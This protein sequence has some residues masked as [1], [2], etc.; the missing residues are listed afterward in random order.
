MNGLFR[1]ANIL[2]KVR[3]HYLCLLPQSNPHNATS[4]RPR[5]SRGET[6]VQLSRR[7]V[8]RKRLRCRLWGRASPHTRA[9]HKWRYSNRAFIHVHGAWLLDSGARRVGPRQ[10]WRPRVTASSEPGKS[11]ARDSQ[12]AA[13]ATHYLLRWKK[14]GKQNDR[15]LLLTTFKSD[16]SRAGRRVRRV[17]ANAPPGRRGRGT[18]RP[19]NGGGGAQGCPRRLTFPPRS[20]GP[21]PREARTLRGTP[22][23]SPRRTR[24]P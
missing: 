11:R 15:A 21:K 22:E 5:H 1:L 6:N 2:P 12:P 13:Q 19:Q 20:Q 3:S 4:P 9:P 24:P 10:E 23:R 18:C 14:K 16:E 7:P 8:R 17:Q